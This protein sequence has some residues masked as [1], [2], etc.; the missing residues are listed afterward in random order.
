[1]RPL[2]AAS[3]FMRPLPAA[4]DICRFSVVLTYYSSRAGVKFL[5]LNSDKLFFIVLCFPSLCPYFS[6]ACLYGFDQAGSVLIQVVAAGSFTLPASSY[7]ASQLRSQ[8][9]GMCAPRIQQTAATGIAVAMS[10]N[11]CCLVVM[12]E[13]TISTPVR[14]ERKRLINSR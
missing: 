14:M 3:C 7:P 8:P 13:M 12:V 9:M 1:M 10:R 11:A 4:S 5:W 2:P 6:G